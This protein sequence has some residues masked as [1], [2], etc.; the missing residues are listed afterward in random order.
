LAQ[1]Y[2]VPAVRAWDAVGFERAKHFA[3]K[4]GINVTSQNPTTAI[5][6]SED[7]VSP[8]QMA[9]AFAAF[10]NEGKYNKASAIVKIQDVA[11]ND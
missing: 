10:G 1:S 9:A 7:T 2:N 6:G 11:G 5:G 4:L 3:G 8:V